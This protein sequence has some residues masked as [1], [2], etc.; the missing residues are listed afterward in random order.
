MTLA[1]PRSVTSDHWEGVQ[2]ATLTIPATVS[3]SKLICL[4]GQHGGAAGTGLPGGVAPVL[5]RFSGANLWSG[6]FE[7]EP[8]VGTTSVTITSYAS[9]FYGLDLTV[10]DQLGLIMG[11]S[12][13]DN[14]NGAAG[15]STDSVTLVTSQS[16]GAT[17]T[18]TSA[19]TLAVAL[20]DT[21]ATYTGTLTASNSY[22]AVMPATGIKRSGAAYK[23]LTA[24][25]ATSTTFGWTTAV[26]AQ[27][28]LAVFKA[29]PGVTNAAPVVTLTATPSV[30]IGETINLT[31]TA[32]DSDGTI[33]SKTLTVVDGGGTGVVTGDIVGATTLTPSV[34]T[35]GKTPG[36][37]QW[38][39]TVVD[40]LGAT[41]TVDAYSTIKTPAAVESIL[42]NGAWR[43]VT[44]KYLVAGAWV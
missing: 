40:N 37:I 32:T 42:Y 14:P 20:L 24:T 17:G 10:I 19:D 8:T 9:G 7:L 21:E 3:G 23:L 1:A 43:D 31:V 11:G 22:T 4:A 33:A 28:V 15:S 36:T 2:S 35:T 29:A 44:D 39:E 34:V 41:T 38:R 6:I 26:A 12:A 18:L 16:T 25:T 13:Y 27:T 5:N 30:S